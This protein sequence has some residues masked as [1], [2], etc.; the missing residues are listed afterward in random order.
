M[1]SKKKIASENE[2]DGEVELSS[3]KKSLSSDLVFELP[4]EITVSGG[5]M[6]APSDK[7]S[8]GARLTYSFISWLSVLVQV[9]SIKTGDDSNLMASGGL[10]LNVPINYNSFY[11]IP[12]ALAGLNM[13]LLSTDLGLGYF[14][15]A[16]LEVG[17]HFEVFGIFAFAEF[18]KQT[19]KTHFDWEDE[20]IEK[21]RPSIG[22]GLSF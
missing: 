13:G 14:A 15:G 20:T 18:T 21:T 4:Y 16:G 10:K 17:Y 2:F 9:D 5:L 22:I 1:D 12:Y 3:P 19:I 7:L 11:I 6:N 8:P